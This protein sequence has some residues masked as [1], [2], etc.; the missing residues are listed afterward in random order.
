M[1]KNTTNTITL[2]RCID[3]RKVDTDE[4]GNP[5]YDSTIADNKNLEATLNQQ[6]SFFKTPE[7][8]VTSYIGEHLDK[9]K[10]YINGDTNVMALCVMYTMTKT[11]YHAHRIKPILLTSSSANGL[12]ILDSGYQV[13][14]TKVSLMWYDILPKIFG[15]EAALRIFRSERK[16]KST[17]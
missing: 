6:R 8:A 4:N 17:I 11:E 12:V 5:I 1:M 15:W 7:R 10:P 14:L 3:I 16:D 9:L 13:D 2:Y